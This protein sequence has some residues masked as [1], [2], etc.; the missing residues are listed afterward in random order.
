MISSFRVGFRL[1]AMT[2]TP[3]LDI[4]LG[5]IQVP[6]TTL[7]EIFAYINEADKPC[8]IAIDE[9]Q[10]IGEYAEKNVEAL[11]RTKIQK[12]QRAQFIF[13][14]S[15]RHMMSN[16]FNS[17]SKPFYQSAISM[18]LEPI[19]IDTYVDFAISLFEDYGKH[20]DKAVIETIWRKYNGYTWFVQMMMNELFALTQKSETCHVDK[21]VEAQHNVIM[22]QESS[23]KDI[24]SR[25][26]PKQK[27]VL[28]AIA[29]EGS[30]QNI[31][32]SK[33]VKKYS[34]NSAS[35]VQAAVKLLLKNDLVTQ[36][37]NTYRV[38]DYFFSEWLATMY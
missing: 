15:K 6:Q 30:A 36:V 35:S 37:D 13:S 3:G 14:G 34:L 17:P 31:T 9:F 12:C 32:S 5:D 16:M 10:Q 11:L 19:P 21:L 8:I 33:F 27:V 25:L 29:K 22:S 18:G 4:G 7:D 28:Q 20:I 24:L 2:G 23:Y 26:P 38:Y 1:D